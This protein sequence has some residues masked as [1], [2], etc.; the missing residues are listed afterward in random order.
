MRQTSRKKERKKGQK[1]RKKKGHRDDEMQTDGV[2]GSRSL[3]LASTNA[4][5]DATGALQ[6]TQGV[7]CRS[8]H[9]RHCPLMDI[10]E[11]TNQRRHYRASMQSESIIQIPAADATFDRPCGRLPRVFEADLLTR[12]RSLKSLE[13]SGISGKLLAVQ[14]QRT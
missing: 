11:C 13:E 5:R 1:W 8:D 14:L 12:G 2:L 3:V 10:Y 7:A 4:T 6:S 9:Y